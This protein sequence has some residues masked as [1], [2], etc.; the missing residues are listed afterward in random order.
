M[1]RR[2][3]EADMQ[4][5]LA[6]LDSQEERD[7]LM[8]RD[9]PAFWARRHL[10]DPDEGK[11]PF[12]AKRGF[13][14]FFLS[15]VRNRALRVGRQVGKT[16]SMCVD[17]L[18]LLAFSHSAVV[19]VF[20]PEKK[21][22]NRIL[23][24]MKNLLNGSDIRLSYRMGKPKRQS[25]NADVED[26]YDYEI[27]CQSGSVVRFFFMKNN[28]DKA[29]GIRATHIIIDEAE[30]IPEKAYA[31]ILG[32]LKRDPNIPITA[33]STPAGIENSWFFDFCHTCARQSKHSEEFHVPTSAEENW[34]EIR[35]RLLD[36]YYDDASW[37][38]EVMA[39]WT[40]AKGAVYRKAI[41]ESSVDRSLIN[42][43]SVAMAALRETI[44]YSDAP[45]VLGVDW[46]DPQ[47][48]VRLVEIARLFGS[49]WISRHEKIA[50]EEY[51]Q[52]RAVQRIVELYDEVHYDCI[53]VD[54]GHGATQIEM[55]YLALSTHPHV[56]A[57]GLDPKKIIMVV[58]SGKKEKTVIEY[59]AGSGRKR[60]VITTRVKTKMIGLLGRYMEDEAGLRI[61]REEDHRDGLV[62]EIK[63]FRRKGA[64]TDGSGFIYSDRS[65][66]LSALLFAV[67]GYDTVIRTIDRKEYRPPVHIAH[68][69]HETV[70][71]LR[72]TEKKGGQ[73]TT[74]EPMIVTSTPRMAR[75][76]RTASLG[77]YHG[78]RRRV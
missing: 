15:P 12:T 29:R 47:N 65:H 66:S 22:M 1:G 14:R 33:A 57:R 16:V 42:G 11:D 5:A 61:P 18:H 78:R 23:E 55:L 53:A 6:L 76:S 9:D 43:I 50:Y 28:P 38:L 17:I 54:A 36:V 44:E 32:L 49:P 68:T 20:V 75:G 67:L 8:E 46:N 27:S 56:K 7:L 2:Y 30:Y 51:T 25:G 39:E 74:N 41:V 4:R 59:A 63:N 73:G 48:G 24:I 62:P 26:R 72:S 64:A 35:E 70:L 19:A 77:E 40:E 10:F 3:S 69:S 31:V 60:D 21:Q 13:L 37:A 52:H 34:D 45:K 71:G 58:E